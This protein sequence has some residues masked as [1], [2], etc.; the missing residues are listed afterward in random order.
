MMR[1]LAERVEDPPHHLA[2]A[3]DLAARQRVGL[4]DRRNTGRR[5]DRT[6][7]EFLGMH[8][9]GGGRWSC[10]LGSRDQKVLIEFI[11]GAPIPSRVVASRT[12]MLPAISRNVTSVGRAVGR[13]ADSAGC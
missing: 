5:L 13:H 8:R 9:L 12:A 10:L 11:A 1:W 4:V 6:N 7:S 2:I 3:D